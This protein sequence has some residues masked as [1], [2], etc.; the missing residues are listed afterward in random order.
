MGKRVLA[1]AAVVAVGIGCCAI[2]A[3]GAEPSVTAHVYAVGPSG[4]DGQ[5]PAWIGGTCGAGAVKAVLRV[6]EPALAPRALPQETTSEDSAVPPSS[7]APPVLEAEEKMELPVT[8]DGFEHIYQVSGAKDIEATCI[9]PDGNA[10]STWITV[11]A[12][13][14]TSPTVTARGAGG[15]SLFHP[16]EVIDVSV[17]GFAPGQ[18]FEVHMRSTPKLIGRGTTDAAGK[19]RI[20]AQIP[21][22]APAGLH[23]LTV[24]A[25]NGQRT[26]IRFLIGDKPKPGAPTLPSADP[27]VPRSADS[28]PQPADTLLRPAGNYEETARRHALTVLRRAPAPERIRAPRAIRPRLPKTGGFANPLPTVHP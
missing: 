27:V 22:D 10:V 16:G 13:Q 1:S 11:D 9:Y 28:L 15:G 25:G 2:P 19:A 5:A 24:R 20:Q 7:E 4:A 6:G 23:H 12:A 3:V 21:R 26:L 17:D 8:D 14:P 18:A